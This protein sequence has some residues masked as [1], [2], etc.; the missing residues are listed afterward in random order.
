MCGGQFLVDPVLNV[1]EELQAVVMLNI[2]SDDEPLSFTDSR[3]ANLF[4]LGCVRPHRHILK[5]N[6]AVMRW[7]QMI[8]KDLG[9]FL[10]RILTAR[11]RLAELLQLLA[12]RM[13]SG[14]SKAGCFAITRVLFHSSIIQ[15]ALSKTNMVYQ[16]ES[17]DIWL[18]SSFN[19]L[20]VSQLPRLSIMLS[21]FLQVYCSNP[22]RQ[23]R[24][25]AHLLPAF[26]LV[27]TDEVV[28][29]LTKETNAYATVEQLYLRLALDWV[30]LGW[31]L[32]LYAPFEEVQAD[33]VIYALMVRFG[34]SFMHKDTSC[35][36]LQP[37]PCPDFIRWKHR[38]GPV[39]HLIVYEAE[40]PVFV[41][42]WRRAVLCS[43]IT[44]HGII[45]G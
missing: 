29:V 43:N 1:L 15:K 31:A 5:M 40:I 16:T 13:R 6:E 10:S 17:F 20:P 38:W 8:E 26:N 3:L 27:M 34:K 11:P 7:N 36:A 35:G 22:A 32:N 14:A 28:S 45:F 37:V 25:L 41:S 24:F 9:S 44:G 30:L 4:G 18:A 19:S 33:Q 12:Q 42:A 21:D 39:D 2:P 23:R